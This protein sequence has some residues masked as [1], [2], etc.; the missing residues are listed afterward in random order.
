MSTIIHLTNNC[1][2]SVT[3]KATD[4]FFFFLEL[5]RDVANSWYTLLERNECIVQADPP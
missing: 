4:F 2:L 3:I 5:K 1:L